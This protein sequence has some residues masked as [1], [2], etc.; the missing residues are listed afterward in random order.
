[1]KHFDVIII[2]AGGA[3]MMCGSTA[4]KLGRSVLLIDHNQKI[5]RKIL[6]SGGGRCN[7]TNVGTRAESFVSNN[8]HISKSAL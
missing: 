5:G 3:G 4:G 7:F 2:G 8:P 6:I 1:L